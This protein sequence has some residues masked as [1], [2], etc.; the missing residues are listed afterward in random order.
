MAFRT[1]IAVHDV[2]EWSVEE[3]IRPSTSGCSSYKVTKIII[4]QKDCDG[5]LATTELNMFGP[6]IPNAESN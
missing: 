3:A 1:S 4:K 5:S 2:Q 6:F